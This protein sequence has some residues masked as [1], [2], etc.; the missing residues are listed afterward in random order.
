MTEKTIWVLFSEQS[1]KCSS[2]AVTNMIL[3]VTNTEEKRPG[4]AQLAGHGLIYK[5]K[6]VALTEYI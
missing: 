3:Q 2:L 4:E 1:S 5:D 6:K